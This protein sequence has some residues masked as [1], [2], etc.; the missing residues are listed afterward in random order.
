MRNLNLRSLSEELKT[1]DEKQHLDRYIGNLRR[2]NGVKA[3]R[4]F[5]YLVPDCDEV[6]NLKNTQLF[7]QLVGVKFDDEIKHVLLCQSC[8]KNAKGLLHIFLRSN[9]D[10]KFYDE[11]RNGYCIHS[12]ALAVMHLETVS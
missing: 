9:I 8:N 3:L 4:H 6:G 10:R 7:V 11:V 5:H 12:K 2:E 1:I